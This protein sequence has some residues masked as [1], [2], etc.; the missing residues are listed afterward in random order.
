MTAVEVD[1]SGDDRYPCRYVFLY[2]WNLIENILILVD[3]LDRNGP[4]FENLVEPHKASMNDGLSFGETMGEESISPKVEDTDLD[5]YRSISLSPSPM[6]NYSADSPMQ[7]KD[8][9]TNESQKV[10][11]FYYGDQKI[12]SQKHDISADTTPSII[13]DIEQ[14]WT[15]QENVDPQIM[16]NKNFTEC[17][18]IVTLGLGILENLAKKSRLLFGQLFYAKNWSHMMRIYSRHPLKVLIMLKEVLA[19]DSSNQNYLQK[20]ENLFNKL[21]SLYKDYSKGVFQTG[22]EKISTDQAIL[23]F[24]WNTI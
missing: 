15:W 13:P 3:Y 16:A 23:L 21:I 9:Y 17:D 12:V 5:S 24:Q 19:R 18:N 10:S 14:S 1:D 7:E 6:K 4:K 8:S 20:D 22:I 11:T 2:Q